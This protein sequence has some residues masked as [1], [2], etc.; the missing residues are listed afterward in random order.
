M[1]AKQQT[2]ITIET[3]EITIIRVSS[4][5]TATVFCFNC[6]KNLKH[7]SI[8]RASAVSKISEAAIFRLVENGQIHSTETA[9]GA[10]LVCSNSLSAVIEA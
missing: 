5:Q 8:A 4:R 2:E 3:H 10:L 1:K 9:A 6:G 7:F